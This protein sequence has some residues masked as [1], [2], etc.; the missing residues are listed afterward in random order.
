MR[1]P[2]ADIADPCGRRVAHAARGECV[3]VRRSRVSQT[4]LATAREW[5]GLVDG[6][7]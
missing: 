7:A 5:R 6:V 2:T 3:A 1:L 4:N